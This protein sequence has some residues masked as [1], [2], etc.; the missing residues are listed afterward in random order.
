MVGRFLRRESCIEKLINWLFNNGGVGRQRRALLVVWVSG[1]QGAGHEGF[2]GFVGLG[3]K[4]GC[5][6]SIQVSRLIFF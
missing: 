2:D 1:F 3:H 4:V 6:N 5:L